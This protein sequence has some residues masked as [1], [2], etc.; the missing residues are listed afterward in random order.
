M[1]LRLRSHAAARNGSTGQFSAS[2][3]SGTEA[4]TLRVTRLTLPACR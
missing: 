2:A 4:N 1:Q 3:C